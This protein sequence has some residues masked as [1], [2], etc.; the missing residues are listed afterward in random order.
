MKKSAYLKTMFQTYGNEITVYPKYKKEYQVKGFIRPLSFQHLPSSNE[1]GIP[2]DHTDDGGYLYLG[3]AEYRIDRELEET[4][5]EQDDVLYWVTKSRAVYLQNEP[6][7]VCAILQKVVASKN[8]GIKHQKIFL[9]PTLSH[10][11]LTN[12]SKIIADMHIS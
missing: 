5:L 6:I 4:K 3:P 9:I 12:W 1:L 11:F 8:Y 7:Y 10:L 2:F